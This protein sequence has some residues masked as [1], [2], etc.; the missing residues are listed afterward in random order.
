M[1]CQIWVK[2]ALTHFWG[3][4]KLSESPLL[5]LNI[6]KKAL[7]ENRQNPTNALRAVLKSAIDSVKPEGDENS[8]ENG[9]FIIFLK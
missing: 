6:V 7:D 2:E 1:R 9:Y 5:E 3:G 8:L 4:P